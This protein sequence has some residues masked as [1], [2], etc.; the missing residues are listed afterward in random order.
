MTTKEL[1]GLAV[2]RL[3][4]PAAKLAEFERLANE[5]RGPEVM[6]ALGIAVEARQLADRI[7]RFITLAEGTLK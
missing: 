3:R 6:K 5:R 1:L 4:V 7:E 2:A